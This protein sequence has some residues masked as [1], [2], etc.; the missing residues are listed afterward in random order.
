MLLSLAGADGG[1]ASAGAVR[2]DGRRRAR[3]AGGLRERRQSAAGAQRHARARA[4]P[5][6][7][8]R[9]AAAAGWCA[10]CSPRASSLATAGGVAG[11]AVAA[12]CHRALLALVGDRIPVPRIEQLTLDLP[13]VA[14]TML[15][16][17]G[18]RHPLR[19][20]S[21][22]RVD[23][24]RA[25]RAPRRRASRRRTPTAQVLRSLV[26]AEV[27]LSLVLLAGAGLLLR[28]FLK[29]QSVDPGFRP[30]VC[31]PPACSSRPRATTCHRRTASSRE[32]SR[33]CRRCRA[34]RASAAATC[35]PVPFACIGTSFWRV[36]R[37]RPADGQLAS[38][39]IRPVTPG[40]FETLGDPPDRRA[41][42]SPRPI[43]SI[44]CRSRSSARSWCG[45]SFRTAARSDAGS[46]STS[47]TPTAAATWSGRSS[48]SFGNLRSYAG[49]PG[50][51]DDL[52]ARDA[53]RQRRASRC[54]SAPRRI[55]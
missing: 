55:R 37:P 8:A 21:G 53:A 42:T 44:R 40:F 13:I 12:W 2:A 51:P 7:G 18:D 48:A 39:Q 17:A 10:R 31:S 52:R 54:S 6:H 32:R 11:L 19:T 30:T 26:V 1:R 22:I 28:S 45:S 33:A 20:R 3:A 24:P 36:D 34:C 4:R 47:A 27:A 35:L 46:A 23:E 14:F 9:R 16:G 38:G 29:L 49:R 5:A 41:A 50:A 15:V 43:P 25:R